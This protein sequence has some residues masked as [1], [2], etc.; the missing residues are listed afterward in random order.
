[1]AIPTLPATFRYHVFPKLGSYDNL[2]LKESPVPT[3]KSGHVL[4]KVH[5][6]RDLA[7]AKGQYPLPG[8]IVND[9]TPCSDM[10]GE[11]VAVGDDV[12]LPWVPGDRVCANFYSEYQAGEPH[13]GIMAGA[14]G[15]PTQG[16]L[17]EYV[18]LP[19]YALIKIPHNLSYEEASTLPCAALTAYTAFSTSKPLKA[20]D[21]VLVLGT[22][23]VATFALQFA[24][25]TGA[26]VIVTSSSDKKLETATKLGAKHVIN[27][28]KTPNWDEVVNELTKGRGVDHVIEVGGPA[29]LARSL[30]ST[31]VGGNIHLIGFL[32]TEQNYDTNVIPLIMF[33]AVNLRGTWLGSA[34]LFNDMNRL[35]E[36]NDVHPV[37]NKVFPFENAVEAFKY[38]ESQAHIG[39]VVIKVTS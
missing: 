5:A 24:V 11:V 9:L 27:Y 16:V 23:G 32:S 8:L 26:E 12:K 17:S 7:V 30:K 14:L 33:K 22:G 15:G 31:R 13:A 39:K 6:F 25:A 19:A 37:V 4:V 2:I 21:T 1:M 18:L 20:G 10:A 28:S 35:I 3:L 29:T 34:A 38:L 36:I